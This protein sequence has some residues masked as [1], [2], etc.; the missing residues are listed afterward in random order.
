V[1]DGEKHAM[2]QRRRGVGQRA[3]VGVDVGVIADVVPLAL[4]KAH[5]VVLPAAQ[6]IAGAVE[7]NAVRVRG[8][9]TIEG[10]FA[11]RRVA[12]VEAVERLPAPVVVRGERGHSRLKQQCRRPFIVSHD[13]D[14]ERLKTG[15]DISPVPSRTRHRRQSREIDSARPGGGFVSGIEPV[16]IAPVAVDESGL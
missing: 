3:Q 6:E 8:V 9:R 11:G 5:H 10:H 4:E 13:E 12:A 2:P 1:A 16:R 15:G 7:A 14:D